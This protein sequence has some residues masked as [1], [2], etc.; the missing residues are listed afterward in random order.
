MRGGAWRGLSIRCRRSL[1][2]S[3]LALLESRPPW[4]FYSAVFSGL[5]EGSVVILVSL[6]R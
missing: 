1:K 6:S 4:L 2:S 5:A 3:P